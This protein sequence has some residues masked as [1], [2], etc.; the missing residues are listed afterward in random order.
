MYDQPAASALCLLACPASRSEAGLVFTARC[1]QPRHRTRSSSMNMYI[2]MPSTFSSASVGAHR[3]VMVCSLG[4]TNAQAAS[5]S[6][7]R[8]PALSALFECLDTFEAM[9]AWSSQARTE[10]A[11]FGRQCGNPLASLVHELSHST[12]SAQVRC[13]QNMQKAVDD[14]V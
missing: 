13:Q 12:K 9:Y 1:T 3:H 10:L 8:L 7:P 6:G 11:G 14:H 4:P 2:V 5:A